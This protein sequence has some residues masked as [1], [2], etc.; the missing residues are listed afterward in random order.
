[1][2]SIFIML[3]VAI[4]L[5]AGIGY[6]ILTI[7]KSG[8]V[9]LSIQKNQARLE[10]VASSIRSG[11][12][13]QEGVALVPVD[14]VGEIPVST[15]P[16]LAPFKETSYGK[17]IVYCPV[18]SQDQAQAEGA[19]VFLDGNDTYAVKTVEIDGRNFI[20]GGR[21][22]FAADFKD[23]VD[24]GLIAA[25]LREQGVAAFLI[26][27]DPTFSATPA[28]SSLTA[29]R[30]PN[31][32]L[33]LLADG[34][35]VT[36]VYGFSSSASRQTFVAVPDGEEGS[37]GWLG[38]IAERVSRQ[39]I[40]ETT[41]RLPTDDTAS[42]ST[43]TGEFEKLANAA[44]GRSLRIVAPVQTALHVS[45][46]SAGRSEIVFKGSVTLDNV[47][48]DGADSAGQPTDVVV[49]AVSGAQVKLTNVVAG[50]LHAAGGSIS[51]SGKDSIVEAEYGAADRPVVVDG[52]DL[53]LEEAVKNGSTVVS[54]NAPSASV[55]F[56]VHGGRLLFVG[57]PKVTTSGSAQP[58]AV[59]G[60]GRL[61]SA[62]PDGAI[63]VSRDGGADTA[64]PVVA[65]MET[66]TEVCA[67]GSASCVAYCSPGRTFVLGSCGS[68]DGHPLAS[69]GLVISGGTGAAGY[70]CEWA[71]PSTGV[72]ENPSA[73]VSCR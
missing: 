51:M 17:P 47:A 39:N 55:V 57:E 53:S 27:P 23:G 1:M 68:S 45:G 21:P 52:G 62:G 59:S 58:F 61:E 32:T 8:E 54:V 6:S 3:I 36:P 41:I 7:I 31:G 44:Q 18:S 71:M 2:L 40:L 13:D 26:S 42:F 19:S 24:Q 28:C 63:S 4:G 33:T 70:K 29:E 34:G 66:A 11:L 30:L 20:T 35:S 50:G 9:S 65:P 64:V 5:C 16:S 25:T 72:P 43:T 67:N 10:M 22:L 14:F 69:F 12:L 46:G 37:T 60:N 15:V 73:E 49:S 38:K 48:L 56:D